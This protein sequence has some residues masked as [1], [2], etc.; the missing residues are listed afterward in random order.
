MGISPGWISRGTAISRVI[1]DMP[2]V[3]L[4]T[5]NFS[6]APLLFGD[7]RHRARPHVD[8]LRGLGIKRDPDRRSGLATLLLEKRHA[9]VDVCAVGSASRHRPTHEPES[10]G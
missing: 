1:R 5:G 6:A 2:V 7:Q 10:G 4:D 3:R 8:K 9:P